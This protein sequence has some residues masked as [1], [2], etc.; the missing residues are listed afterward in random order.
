MKKEWQITSLQLTPQPGSFSTC[1]NYT[2]RYF[3]DWGNYTKG[4]LNLK[5]PNWGFF[6]ISKLF[7]FS[8]HR[9]N[10]LDWTPFQNT[11]LKETKAFL[12]RTRISPPV[13]LRRKYSTWCLNFVCLFWELDLCIQKVYFWCLSN[14]L[15]FWV[16][17]VWL[18]QLSAAFSCFN[19]CC[20]S[21]YNKGLC[22]LS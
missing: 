22:L 21:L 7:F 8:V 9:K 5:W 12:G 13:P 16:V 2:C 11:N 14:R 18:C 15:E 3:L 19:L 17:F 10:L 6:D 4:D 1:G 20:V